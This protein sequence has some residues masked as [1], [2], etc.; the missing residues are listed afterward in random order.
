MGSH[1]GK[2]VSQFF[3]SYEQAMTCTGETDLALM[4]T[5]YIS[6]SFIWC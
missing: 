4:V 6:D 3:S 2:A 5:E 1:S